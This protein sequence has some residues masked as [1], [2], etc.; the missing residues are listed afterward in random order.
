[1]ET[2]D[3]TFSQ[4]WKYPCFPAL[5]VLY[6]CISTFVLEL[7]ISAFQLFPCLLGH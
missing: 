2:V 3:S 1:M 5:R 6:S 4:D 7:P